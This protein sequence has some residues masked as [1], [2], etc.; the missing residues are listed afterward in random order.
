M[1]IALERLI[2]RLRSET[3]LSSDPWKQVNVYIAV[4][5]ALEAAIAEAKGRVLGSAVAWGADGQELARRAHEATRALGN[6]GL[7]ISESCEAMRVDDSNDA[8]IQQVIL[9][10]LANY[11]SCLRWSALLRNGRNNASYPAVHS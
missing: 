10:A 4:D 8:Q 9:V 2:E 11:G 1:N 6:I 5:N 3:A 7:F